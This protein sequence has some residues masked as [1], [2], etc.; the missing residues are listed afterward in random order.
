[1]VQAEAVG[2]FVVRLLSA[3]AILICSTPCW[4][5]VER[6]AEAAL[7]ECR[8]ATVLE[9]DRVPDTLAPGQLTNATACMNYLYG[10]LDGYYKG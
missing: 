3:I 9:Q 4:A 1:M 7:S 8:D 5:L 10:V 2:G 6:P